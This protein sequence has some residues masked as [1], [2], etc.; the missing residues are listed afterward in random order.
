[1]D[2]YPTTVNFD[3]KAEELS[4]QIF[5]LLQPINSWLLNV[6]KANGSVL[7][8]IDEE[9][10][11][12]E[13]KAIIRGAGFVSLMIRRSP[14]IFHFV[15]ASPGT[16]FDKE[17]H[18]SINGDYYSASKKRLIK[19]SN[20]EKRIY[21]EWASMPTRTEEEMA[22]MKYI[23][24]Q[25]RAM[26][27]IG[28]TP[29]IRIYKPGRDQ[30]PPPLEQEPDFGHDGFRIFMLR[31]ASILCHWGVTNFQEFE[32][33]P[34]QTVK[35]HMKFLKDRSDIRQPWLSGL[36]W[37]SIGCL[38]VACYFIKEVTR[39][40]WGNVRG[41]LDERLPTASSSSLFYKPITVFVSPVL[42]KTLAES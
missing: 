41:N 36:Y 22:K 39:N 42:I 18:F 15:S 10:Q 38:G 1:M 20:Y 9:S 5:L 28:I 12:K 2:G 29:T 6:P 33:R 23:K 37:L 8:S 26:V 30:S 25:M 24:P 40:N 31:Q 21:N 4:R 3:A 34:K 14:N 11:L 17:D 16:Y 13:L 19:E 27:K 7:Q 35:G 32:H